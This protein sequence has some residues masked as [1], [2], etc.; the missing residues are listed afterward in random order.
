M[1]T[2]TREGFEAGLSME[3]E[4][5]REN[6]LSPDAREGIDSFLTGR[7]PEFTGKD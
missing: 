6:I 3:Y 1:I 2:G 7:K 5:F 4:T